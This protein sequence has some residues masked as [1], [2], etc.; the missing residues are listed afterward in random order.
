MTSLQV[1]AEVA[2]PAAVDRPGE[3]EET[4]L[5]AL[6]VMIGRSVDAENAIHGL[7]NEVRQLRADLFALDHKHRRDLLW[8]AEREAVVSSAIFAQQYL[9][10]A[11]TFHDSAATMT[12]AVGMVQVDGMALEFGV[13]TGRT[14]TAIAAALPDRAVYGFDVFSGLPED[15]RTGAPK[16][17]FAQAAP[18]V[19]GATIVQGLF[20]E[21]LPSFV[22]EHP[23]PV[24]F[25]HL[26][27]DLYSSTVTVL[28][29]IGS[30]LVAGS[31][32]LFDEYFNYASWQ[33]HEHKAWHEFVDRTGLQFEYVGYTHNDEQLIVRVTAPGSRAGS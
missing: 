25:L 7:T 24:A 3:F 30:R 29:H 21:T 15:W 22:A 26:D 11:L 33:Q 10:K 12:H 14:L 5:R 4:V 18:T 6:S 27:A 19:Q 28:N 32:V 13:A 1:G 8:A 9:P 16:G 23:G 17:L 2:A 20:D 31:I